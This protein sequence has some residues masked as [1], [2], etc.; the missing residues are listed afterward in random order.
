MLLLSLLL[1]WGLILTL[2]WCTPSFPA[3]HHGIN[4]RKTSFRDPSEWQLAAFGKSGESMRAWPAERKPYAS[5]Q[6]SALRPS[7]FKRFSKEVCLRS[8]R[9]MAPKNVTDMLARSREL[10]QASLYA[11]SLKMVGAWA[12]PR[13]HMKCQD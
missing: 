11:N 10:E 1:L 6:S 8:V 12:T 5:N 2:I 7:S 4:E 13:V 3:L 9:E